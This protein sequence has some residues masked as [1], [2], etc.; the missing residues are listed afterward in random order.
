MTRNYIPGIDDEYI[1]TRPEYAK[2]LGISSN[3]LRMKMRR[4]AFGEEYVVKNG[5]YVFKRPRVSK[6]NRPAGIVDPYKQI[7]EKNY[8]YKKAPVKRGTHFENN[9]TSDAMR[10]HNEFKMYNKITG[11]VGQKVLDEINPEVIKIAQE[12]AE[13]KRKEARKI[14][15]SYRDWKPTRRS[16][17]ID[18]PEGRNQGSIF[19]GRVPYEAPQ[20]VESVRYVF[21]K[22]KIKPEYKLSGN[23]RLKH[24]EEAIKNAKKK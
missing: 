15:D 3:A 16:M 22:K 5:N 8:K 7:K 9:Y 17:P 11:K 20:P 18:I 13:A 2:Q 10:K 24:L 14:A 4:G 12:R 23:P 6:E 21:P 19:I 1:F